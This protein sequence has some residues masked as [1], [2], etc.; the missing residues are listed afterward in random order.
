MTLDKSWFYLWTS[1]ETIWIQ[2]G[3]QPPERVKHMNWE[4]KMMVTI[5]W[6]P[7]DFHLVD[8]LP[9]GQKFNA[10]YYIDRILQP[11]LESR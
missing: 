8:A 4:R 7:Q 11:F 3:Q 5:I 10:N 2:A 1:H 9:K 6:N